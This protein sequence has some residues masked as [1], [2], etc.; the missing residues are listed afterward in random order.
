MRTA[1]K[2]LLAVGSGLGVWVVT[3]FDSSGISDIALVVLVLSVGAI[4]A[5]EKT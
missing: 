1:G 2:I 5:G 4:L 3:H